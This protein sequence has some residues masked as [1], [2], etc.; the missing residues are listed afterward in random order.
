MG[1]SLVL[2]G[3]HPLYST[4]YGGS[5]WSAEGSRSTAPAT[6]DRQLD[7]STDL[8]P[9]APQPTYSGRVDAVRLALQAGGRAAVLLVPTAVR[10]RTPA[11][12]V[13]VLEAGRSSSTARPR[14]TS[15]SPRHSSR[16]RRRARCVR[17]GDLAGRRSP[18]RPTSAA[19]GANG[20]GRRAQPAGKLI[21]AGQT[22]S[23]DLPMLGRADATAGNRDTFV[24][25]LDPPYT[26]FTYATYLGSSNN[27]EGRA[28]PSTAS[29]ASSSR[30]RRAIRSRA[31]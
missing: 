18:R 5:G 31:R 8:P 21:F 29:A 30:A 26:T 20:A 12:A 6:S 23:P 24:V 15:R 11:S 7:D 19:R 9:D 27:D 25:E 14:R 16:P 3:R 13:V 1:S 2:V 10:A 22:L 28:W 17:S 4:Y